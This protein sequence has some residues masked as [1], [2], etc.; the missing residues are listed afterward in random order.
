MGGQYNPMDPKSGIVEI[1]QADRSLFF[2][3]LGDHAEQPVVHRCGNAELL[4]IP[5][6][7]NCLNNRLRD[8]EIE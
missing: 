2:F 1:R 5:A 8:S 6:D 3:D 7:V 4:S